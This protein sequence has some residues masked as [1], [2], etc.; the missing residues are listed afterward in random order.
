MKFLQPA[1]WG[2]A[3]GYAHG[4]ATAGTI[5]FVSGQVGWDEQHR[6]SSSALAGQV[7]TA[8][9]NIVAVLSAAGARHDQVTRLTWYVTD[10][11]EYLRSQREIGEA[12]RAVMGF[13]YPAMSVVEVSALVEEQALVEI[14]ATAVI[15][16]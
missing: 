2:R 10:K 6:F 15:P 9:E 4:V 3:K 16:A 1:G 12:Y 14:E 8:L 11:R 7:R 5:V 13:H